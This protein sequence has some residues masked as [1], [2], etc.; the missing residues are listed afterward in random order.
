[1]LLRPSDRLVPAWLLICLLEPGFL[2][3]VAEMTSGSLHPHLNM[4]DIARLRVP[5][6]ERSVQDALAVEGLRLSAAREEVRS[7]A[8]A[9]VAL[10]EERKRSL[11]T[12]CVTGEFDVST[13]SAR[14]GDAALCHIELGPAKVQ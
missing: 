2:E 11:I 14:A 6:P 12:A 8:Q 10:L 1:V 7:V 9:L 3:R 4:A 13:A 5:V